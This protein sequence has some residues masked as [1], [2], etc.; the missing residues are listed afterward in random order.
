MRCPIATLVLVAVIAPAAARDEIQ[1]FECIAQNRLVG[2]E[3][4]RMDSPPAR[5]PDGRPREMDKGDAGYTG[6][7]KG[8][9][10]PEW[11]DLFATPRGHGNTYLGFY[12]ARDFKCTGVEG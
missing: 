10:A 4:A 5:W 12:L 2:R 11:I 6:L 7:G 8:E 1:M 3:Q 9:P